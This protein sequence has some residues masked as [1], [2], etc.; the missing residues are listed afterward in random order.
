MLE[1]GG[2]MNRPAVDTLHKDFGKALD[3][4]ERPPNGQCE[5]CK[6][7][8]N[9]KLHP[10]YDCS[11]NVCAHS[12]SQRHRGWVCKGCHSLL[13][14]IDQVGFQKLNEYLSRRSIGDPRPRKPDDGHC[15]LCDCPPRRGPLNLDHC[16]FLEDLGF[17]K[18]EWDRGYVCD[19]CN[20]PMLARVDKIGTAKLWK[21]LSRKG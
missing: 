5:L 9:R 7:A 12:L 6:K 2:V 19:R 3:A 8:E 13:E 4:S 20:S 10:D 21:Y 16:H 11:P 15:E 1:G 17:P 18:A 14:W